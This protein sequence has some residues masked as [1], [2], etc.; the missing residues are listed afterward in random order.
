MKFSFIIPALNEEDYIE[1]CISS[2][3]R[4]T[5]KP[6]EIIVVDN[7]STDKTAEIAKRLGCRV[8]KE[9]RK[10]ISNA[11]NKGAK[12]A[13]GD[14]LCFIDAD[15]VLTKDWVKEAKKVFLDKEVQAADGLIIYTHK[16]WL[17]RILYNI[18]VVFAYTGIFLSELF[19]SRHWFIGNNT[20]IRNDVFW[21]LGGF[22]PL[23]VEQAWLSKKFWKLPN[24]K[25]KTSLK[26][27]VYYSSRAFENTNHLILLY[28]WA[29]TGFIKKIHQK[30]YSYK[31]KKR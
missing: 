18:H 4:Q 8:V 1:D 31:S 17:K 22:E 27:I 19:L 23:V 6:Y 12:V 30:G 24:H 26:M 2:I 28:Y 7:D 9:K 15:G 3:K 20:A 25:A 11:R 16:D 29:K 13:K 10:G 14:I 21:K 5:V